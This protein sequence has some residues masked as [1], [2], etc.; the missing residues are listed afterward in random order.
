MTASSFL[1][2]LEIAKL[3]EMRYLDAMNEPWDP[4]TSIERSLAHRH[5][6]Y[7]QRVT[8]KHSYSPHVP[9]I[10][11]KG[12][13][14]KVGFFNGD[15][16]WIPMEVARVD[17]PHSLSMQSTKRF[18]N[19]PVGEDITRKHQNRCPP[20]CQNRLWARRYK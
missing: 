18:Q 19:T 13:R 7:C 11:T 4:H 12:V 6:R 15:T 8:G 20:I 14:M 1:S 5:T 10:T 3:K 9:C 17:K 16:G 2:P